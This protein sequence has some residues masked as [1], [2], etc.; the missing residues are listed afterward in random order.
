M[1]PILSEVYST[2]LPAAPYVIGAYVGIWL[3]LAVFVFVLFRRAKHT[4]QDVEA[5]KEAL[6]ARK[7]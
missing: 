2:V 3:V 1:D 5:L 6:D 4:S 7:N